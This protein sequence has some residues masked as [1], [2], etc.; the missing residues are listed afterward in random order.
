M[1]MTGRVREIIEMNTT[2]QYIPLVSMGRDGARIFPMYF[3]RIIGEHMLVMP[4][5]AG[6][7]IGKTLARSTPAM[8]LV[9]DRA[10]GYEAYVLEGKARYV[11][12]KL[13]LELVAAMQNMVPGFPVHGAVVFDVREVHLVPPP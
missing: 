8:A 4:A 2:N 10:G 1:R 9:A 11:T 3:A 6:T 5:T 7:G 13:D 12:D